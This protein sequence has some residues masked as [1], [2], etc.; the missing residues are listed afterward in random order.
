MSEEFNH[1]ILDV[2]ASVSNGKLITGV[3]RRTG[4]GYQCLLGGQWHKHNNCIPILYPSPE[5]CTWTLPTANAYINP[6]LLNPWGEMYERAHFGRKVE[7]QDVANVSYSSWGSQSTESIFVS[8]FS[9]QLHPPSLSFPQ[10]LIRLATK[11]ISQNLNCILFQTREAFISPK[12]I[13]FCQYIL[14]KVSCF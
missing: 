10:T 5:V 1:L 6:M 9:F 7:N 13:C 8:H 3:G 14:K 2:C 4:E 11:Q 12:H